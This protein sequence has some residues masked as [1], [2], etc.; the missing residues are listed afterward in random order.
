MR[1]LCQKMSIFV[2]RIA[3]W[4][5]GGH[6]LEKQRLLTLFFKIRF[7]KD[8]F[9]TRVSV[10]KIAV[11]RQLCFS[12]LAGRFRNR[13]SLFF[14]LAGLEIGYKCIIFVT[15]VYFLLQCNFWLQMSNF[16]QAA[17][18]FCVFGHFFQFLS[19]FWVKSAPQS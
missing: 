4:Q 2:L 5:Q 7:K 15:N 16:G 1:T 11:V 12:P 14:S 3:V 18:Y 6:F 8:R 13:G 9:F 17:S 19:N 10:S